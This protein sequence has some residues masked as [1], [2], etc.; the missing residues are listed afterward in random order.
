MPRIN[1]PQQPNSA[2]SG[3]SEPHG[4]FNDNANRLWSLYAEKAKV[5]DDAK[6]ETLT[7]GMTG[8]LLFAGLFA[9]ALTPFI[10]DRVQTIQ[11]T[12]PQQMVF[13]EQQ[14]VELL[15]QISAQLSSAFPQASIPS[16]S[17]LPPLTANPSPSDKRVNVLWFISLVLSLSAALL[18]TLVQRWA[19]SHMQIFLRYKHPLKLSRIR[20]YLHEGVEHWHMAAIAEAV[21][22]LIHIALFLFMCGLADFLMHAD[23]TV[24]APTMFII[25]LYF[26]F[27][28]ITTILPLWKPQ[29][30]LRSPFSV[31]L[32]FLA[33]AVPFRLYR[34]RVD[35]EMKPVSQ[36]MADGQME[37]ALETKPI[38]RYRDRRA[39]AW[40]VGGLTEDV[41]MES[42]ALSIPGSFNPEW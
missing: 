30:P 9:A 41:E 32:W 36:N 19:R 38:R 8:V 10:V 35:G 21:P 22:A 18:A 17:P 7:E 3:S 13:Y 33:Q 20:Q 15:K 23:V 16:P 14:S 27:Y 25:V 37:L 26:M 12:P 29:F 24:G 6:I 39:I 1:E 34:D 42:F 5:H 2:V 40:L 4:D 31:M 28:T 11:V